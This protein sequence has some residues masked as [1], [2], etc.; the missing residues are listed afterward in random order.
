[1]SEALWIF[2]YGSLVWRPA[3]EFA[4]R[5]A[6]VLRGYERRFWQASIDHRGVPGAP[7]RVATLIER[8]EGQCVGVVFRVADE[9]RA[10]VL[11]QLDHRERGGYEQRFV[12]VD[13][14]KDR[15]VRALVYFASPSNRNWLG[16]ASARELALQIRDASGPSGTNV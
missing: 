12:D 2:G 9:R 1:V 6:A 11:A 15:S 3:F 13:T 16:E 10:E 8:P 14:G 7:G 4:E 5:R